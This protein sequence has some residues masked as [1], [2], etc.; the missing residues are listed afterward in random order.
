[1]LND[2]DDGLEGRADL[3]VLRGERPLRE[4]GGRGQGLGGVDRLERQ[5][6]ALVRAVRDR[7]HVAARVGVE[8]FLLELVPEQLDFRRLED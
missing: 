6:C 4:E 5:A 1:V 7:E 2:L 8:A 3:G